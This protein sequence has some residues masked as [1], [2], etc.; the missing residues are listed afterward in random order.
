MRRLDALNGDYPCYVDP[1]SAPT[2]YLS[3]ALPVARAGLGIENLSRPDERTVSTR[4]TEPASETVSPRPEQSSDD[5]G[6]DDDTYLTDEEE[7][8]A[9]GSRPARALA[10]SRA[11]E[12][13]PSPAPRK[14]RRPA[15]ESRVQPRGARGE[16]GT[17]VQG[18][19]AG[20]ELASVPN[21]EEVNADE[22]KPPDVSTRQQA[23]PEDE[24]DA[25]QYE[26]ERHG[27]IELALDEGVEVHSPPPITT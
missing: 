12:R 24:E 14:L 7:G 3:G 22:V 6:E 2:S 25:G 4:T 23:A 17:A 8:Y 27:L 18:A 11:A 21:E 5:S 16:P 15:P 20:G 19:R 26:N 10:A 13:R 9:A 1:C